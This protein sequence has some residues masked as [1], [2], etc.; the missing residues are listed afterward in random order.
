MIFFTWKVIKFIGISRV[1]SYLLYLYKYIHF[2][3]IFYIVY[4]YY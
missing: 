2:L 3:F 1:F 4:S